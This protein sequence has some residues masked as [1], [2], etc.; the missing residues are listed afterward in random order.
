MPRHFIENKRQ[1]HRLHHEL[2]VTYRSVGSFL[3]DW[4]TDISRG[5]LFINTSKALPVGTTVRLLIQLPDG[6]LPVDITG[7]V[8]RVAGLD[9]APNSAPGMGIEFTDLDG[10]KRQEIEALVE[11]LRDTLDPG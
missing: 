11:R 8:T 9:D 2:P 10:A 6:Q 7:R 4:A 5:G 3:S 1:S